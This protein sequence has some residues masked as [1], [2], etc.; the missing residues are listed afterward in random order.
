MAKKLTKDEF[1]KRATSVH[2]AKYGYSKVEYV[3]RRTKVSIICP[4]HGEFLIIPANHLKG[5]GCPKCAVIN[6][7]RG[8]HIDT[9]E[10]IRRAK[11]K[12]GGTYDYSKVYYVN[13]RTKVTIICPKHGEFQKM[14]ISFLSGS[15]C[16]KCTEERLGM[17][18]D[19]DTEK[20][21]KRAN[22]VHNNFYDYSKVDY[23]NN[24]TK[25]IIKC[26]IHGE[27]L[28]RPADHLRGQ[29]CPQCGIIKYSSKRAL[30]KDEFIKK[31]N[32][33]HHNK[34]DYSK[35]DYVNNST[36][37][38]IIC[39]KHGEFLMT[40]ANHMSG[41]GCPICAD[42]RLGRESHINK[43]KFI[44][45]AIDKY[46]DRYDYSKV[47]Y[48]DSR[49]KVTIICPKHGEFQKVPEN[50]WAG[51]GCPKCTEDRLG[52]EFDINTGK[53]IKKAN[54]VHNDFYDDSKVDYKNNNTKVI[55]KCPIHG[56]FLQR[57]ADHL[58]GQGCP[59]C[60]IIK[61][62]ENRALDKDEFIKRAREIHGKRYNYSLVDYQNVR[63]KVK[64]ICP[65]HGVFEQSP[66][67]H[68]LQKA[69]CPK[70]ADEK[71]GENLKKTQEQFIEEAHSIHGDKYD[72]SKAVYQG[73]DKKV[74][75]ICPKHGE[76][77]QTAIVHLNG[78]G[79]PKCR[80]SRLENKV[81]RMLDKNNIS[82]K[83]QKRFAWLRSTYTMPLDFYL[84]DMRLAVECQGLQHF[85]ITKPYKNSLFKNLDSIKQRDKLKYDLC[86]EH[87][88]RIIYFCDE[89]ELVMPKKYFD[90]IFCS[91]HELELFLKGEN[92]NR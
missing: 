36:K 61:N 29:G 76:F 49:T 88:I 90:T 40:P 14:P 1:I 85:G 31:A 46:G 92:V 16:P 52:R 57:P 19:M 91:L 87:G 33:V 9:D 69:G 56:E 15:E 27:F 13:N 4:E 7:G 82:Y 24:H 50:F 75:I 64:I 41:Q 59:K 86:N 47:N 2:K 23:K 38:V 17:K 89:S 6:R 81:M 63:K 78:C 66:E 10:F 21:I 12:Y 37:I 79:C 60:G 11:D 53:F 68:I 25:V 45:R 83:M 77:A 51:S 72:Y 3:N 80:N 74:I 70:C 62:S 30:G 18:F 8:I 26:P 43:D 55:I 22:S 58:R 32:Y 48:V 20:F 42:K 35:V 44:E 28:Q 65:I 39:P 34:Y 84:P 73:A 71:N 67:V 5:Q 54:D